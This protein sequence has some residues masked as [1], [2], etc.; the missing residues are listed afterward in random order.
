MGRFQC[1][2]REGERFFA[3]TTG[4]DNVAPDVEVG[5]AWGN[6]I[7]GRGR[8]DR[9]R[10]KRHGLVGDEGVQYKC[11]CGKRGP[12]RSSSLMQ[13]LTAVLAARAGSAG[14]LSI[15]YNYLTSRE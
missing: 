13:T 2:Q 9:R 3:P 8:K 10:E 6:L 12:V 7:S 11:L 4:V 1:K 14:D 15:F 5:G